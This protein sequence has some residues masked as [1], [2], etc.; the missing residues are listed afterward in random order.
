MCEWKPV[1]IHARAWRA[2]YGTGNTSQGLIVSIHA[3]AWRAT[4]DGYLL[5]S[6]SYSFNSRPRVAGD[7]CRRSSCRSSWCFNSRPRVAGDGT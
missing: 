7:P 4:S 5:C 1:S 3:R 2:T 6:G